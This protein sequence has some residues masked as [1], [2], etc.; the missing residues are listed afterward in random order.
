MEITPP[1]ILEYATLNGKIPFREWLSGLR[2]RKA[3]AIIDA[4]IA[5]VR[6]GTF[7]PWRSVGLGAK[8][9]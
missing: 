9:R 6:R 2:D 5:N 7:G 8:R 1:R 3:Q 4:R